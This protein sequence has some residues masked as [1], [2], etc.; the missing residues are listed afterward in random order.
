MRIF[1]S[2][3]YKRK[4]EIQRYADQASNAGLEVCSAWHSLESS[5]SDGFSGIGEERLSWLAMMDLQQLAGSNALISFADPQSDFAAC[6]RRHL[7]TGA[8]LALG[9][10]VLH[11]GDLENQYQA[12]HGVQRFACWPECFARLLE[13]HKTDQM[14]TRQA[15]REAGISRAKID[16]L[17]RAG[18]LAAA[19]QENG[20]YLVHRN[21][22]DQ[23]KA[24]QA[25]IDADRRAQLPLPIIEA[26]SPVIIPLTLNERT[27]RV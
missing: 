27:T 26:N 17:I 1:L 8:A 19:K 18:R 23:Y 16:N 14:T 24:N 4:A 12:L 22:L 9:K 10:I 11:V 6:S 20:R 5:S 15:A 2:A 21:H 7:E 13:L 3:H 25:H